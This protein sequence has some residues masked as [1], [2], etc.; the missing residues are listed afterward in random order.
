MSDPRQHIM[1]VYRPP[2][3]AFERGEGSWLFDTQGKKYLDLL[4][5]IAVVSL[6]HS[7]PKVTEAIRDQA[8]KLMQ[9]SNGFQIPEQTRLAET[10]CRLTGMDNVFFCSTEFSH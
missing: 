1:P 6:G 3:E 7:H 8:G 10:M 2:E 5:G 9:V 4:V